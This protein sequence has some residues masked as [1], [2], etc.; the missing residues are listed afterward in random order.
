MLLAK[1]PILKIANDSKESEHTVGTQVTSFQSVPGG[2]SGLW[3]GE[4][5]MVTS[6]G[7]IRGYRSKIV[8]REDKQSNKPSKFL[9]VGDFLDP[10]IVLGAQP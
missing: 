2:G 3:P 6:Y 8:K 4:Q 9:E 7:V 10:E 5:L 1:W